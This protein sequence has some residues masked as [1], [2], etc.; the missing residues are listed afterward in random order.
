MK[1]YLPL[2][3]IIFI[4]LVSSFAVFNLLNK[5]PKEKTSVQTGQEDIAGIVSLI[6]EYDKDN[7]ATYSG[8]L[9]QGTTAFSILE[10]IAN[11]ESIIV[12]TKKYDFGTMV[13]SIGDN[14]NSKEKAWI[15]FVNK[16]AG[17]VAADK[18]TLNAGDVVEWKFI[19]PEY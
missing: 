16:T 8:E 7:I 10:E 14:K 5:I 1:K 3:A 15:Y 11:K 9:K 6:L 18:K 13:E 17:D 19:K 12:E 2:I 4:L